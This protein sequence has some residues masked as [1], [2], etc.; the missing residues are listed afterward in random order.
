MVTLS[1]IPRRLEERY[2]RLLGARASQSLRWS[3]RRIAR[4]G[5]RQPRIA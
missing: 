3:L 4:E 5:E 1:K 2:R